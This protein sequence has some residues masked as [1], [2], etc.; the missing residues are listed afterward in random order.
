M[1]LYI[2]APIR[3]QRG[4]KEE[5]PFCVERGKIAAIDRKSKPEIAAIDLKSKPEILDEVKPAS[6][7]TSDWCY[8]V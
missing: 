2:H 8:L 5:G 7:V 3:L 1:E 6:T 4:A